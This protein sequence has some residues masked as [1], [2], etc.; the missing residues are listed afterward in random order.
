MTWPEWLSLIFQRAIGSLWML[1][2]MLAQLWPAA[3][4]VLLWKIW[5]ALDE[6]LGELKKRPL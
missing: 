1:L 4:L 5:K 3:L 2:I 6:I